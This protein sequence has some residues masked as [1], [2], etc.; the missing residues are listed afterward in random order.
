MPKN[1]ADPYCQLGAAIMLRAVRDILKKNTY[2]PSATCFILFDDLADMIMTTLRLDRGAVIEEL[3]LETGSHTWWRVGTGG[4]I[5]FNS[6]E[7]SK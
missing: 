6:R 2:A 4:H 1:Y 7:V 5:Y 3:G